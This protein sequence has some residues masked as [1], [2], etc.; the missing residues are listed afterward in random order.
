MSDTPELIWLENDWSQEFDETCANV[1][2]QDKELICSWRRIPYVPQSLLATEREKFTMH[3]A[4]VNAWLALLAEAFGVNEEKI[5]EA[6]SAIHDAAI[7]QAAT[8]ESLQARLGYHKEFAELFDGSFVALWLN[9]C[10]QKE[11]IEARAERIAELNSDL[12]HYQELLGDA[13]Q[14][15]EGT[16]LARIESLQAENERMRNKIAE[17]IDGR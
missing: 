12:D 13:H 1:F 17:F 7:S 6:C 11:T 15:R 16:P 2:D 8:I 9:Y 5:S 10:E 4:E 14:P 3:T